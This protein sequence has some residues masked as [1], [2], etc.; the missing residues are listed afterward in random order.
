MNL[1]LLIILISLVGYVSNWINWR[2]LNY[3]IVRWLYYL[4]ATVHESSHA[5]LCI[6][7]GAKITEFSIFSKQPHVTHYKSR[8][9]ILGGILIS[10]APIA[11]GLLF[12]FLLNKYFLEINLIIPNLSDWQGILRAPLK[13][14]AQLNLFSW[15][16]WLLIFISLNIGAMISPSW[17]DLKNI[18]PLIV[19]LLFFSNSFLTH[20]GLLAVAL[21]FTNIII[22]IILL[23]IISAIKLVRFFVVN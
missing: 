6:L 1:G 7:T 5:V 22:Q 10:I 9:P 18:W 3:S 19:I 12:L 20:F 11:G 4:G 13:I 8:L 16:G 15:Q 17:Q 14:L 21:I 2:F 23:A